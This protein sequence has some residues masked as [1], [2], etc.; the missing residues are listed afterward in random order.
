[1]ED[2]VVNALRA[3]NLWDTVVIYECIR[4]AVPVEALSD[5]AIAEIAF[6]Y[7]GYYDRT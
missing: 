5:D 1:M 2:E 3:V 4:D 7:G 6:A